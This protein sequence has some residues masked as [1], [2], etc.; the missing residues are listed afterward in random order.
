MILVERVAVVRC[1]RDYGDV[2]LRNVEWLPKGLTAWWPV[3]DERI[4][5]GVVVLLDSAHSERIKVWVGRSKGVGLCKVNRRHSDRR[6]TLQVDGPFQ[7]LGWMQAPGIGSFLGRVPGNLLTY[8]ER[9]RD[10]SPVLDWT[11]TPRARPERG[12]DP[13][14]SGERTSVAPGSY[15]A[16]GRHAEVVNSLYAWLHTKQGYTHLD[17][18]LGWH[19][20]HGYDAKGNSAL[21]E[22]KTSA[23]NSDVYG[24]LGQLQI[25]ELLTGPSRKAVVLP[26]EQNA[27]RIWHERLYELD[28]GL[29]TF[30]TTKAGYVFREAVPAEH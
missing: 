10:F 12:F 25:Y 17:N 30:E 6:W 18:I 26:Q 29:I 16:N 3:G 1:K 19:D 8:V 20:L 11:V 9:D 24:A 22:V 7:C 14:R 27:E 28:P 2:Y 4:F 21:F 13:E 23:N 15:T 5:G